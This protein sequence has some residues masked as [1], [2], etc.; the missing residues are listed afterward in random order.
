M[1]LLQA[2]PR[3]VFHMLVLALQK[4]LLTRLIICLLLCLRV[5]EGSRLGQTAPQVLHQP[6]TLEL[7]ALV[8]HLYAVATAVKA[9]RRL[10]LL[11]LQ[12]AVSQFV[13]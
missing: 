6:T 10:R 8:S 4:N 11:K 5:A 3:H 1:L 2:T 12:L 7:H 13:V 9:C